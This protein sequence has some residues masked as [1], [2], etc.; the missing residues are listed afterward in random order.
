[1]IQTQSLHK[2]DAFNFEKIR[3]FLGKML[4]SPAYIDAHDGIKL[5]YYSFIPQNPK[6]T[7]IFY[8]GGGLWSGGVY[9]CMAHIL[10]QE[11]GIA[12]YLFDTRGHGYSDGKRG[13]TPTPDAI[14]KDV[15]SAITFINK[16]HPG[17]PLF[18]AGHSSGAG[19]ILNYDCYKK[20]TQ[21]VTGYLLFAPFLGGDSGTVREAQKLVRVKT[22]PFIAYGITGLN[23]LTHIKTLF[24]NYPAWLKKIDKNVLDYYSCGMAIATSPYGIKEKFP[25][26]ATPFALFV[27]DQEEQFYPEK[28]TAYKE[29]ATKVK[30][31][32][33][34]MIV[35]GVTHLSIIIEAPQLCA[36]AIDKI[37]QKSH[38]L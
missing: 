25:E 33:I 16:K 7:I 19:L 13:D 8:H 35:P 17:L 21:N 34:S 22:W 36:Q 24:F 38:R 30:D 4:A 15:D 29:L 28:V 18:L 12:T 20:H 9:H 37:T 32:S 23:C 3:P 1:M 14:W 11:Y 26:I 2:Q 5:A 31:Q 6:A 27:G 10:A